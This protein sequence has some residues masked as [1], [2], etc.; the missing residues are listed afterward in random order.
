[1]I[2][3]IVPPGWYSILARLGSGEDVRLQAG[4]I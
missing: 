2:V 4:V 3:E 1:V